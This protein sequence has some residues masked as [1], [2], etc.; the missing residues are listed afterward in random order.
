MEGLKVLYEQRYSLLEQFCSALNSRQPRKVFVHDLPTSH[1][2]H[3]LSASFI[4]RENLV[5]TYRVSL[6]ATE[7][8][9]AHLQTLIEQTKLLQMPVTEGLVVI[10]DGL[11]VQAFVTTAPHIENR[12]QAVYDAWHEAL[13]DFPLMETAVVYALEAKGNVI[14]ARHDDQV[15]ALWLDGRGE[16][17]L[18]N[19]LAQLTDYL[20]QA[21]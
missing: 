3:L 13:S 10:S 4:D 6:P 17:T 11:T 7:N 9:E 16:R 12:A 21:E 15:L 19:T 2:Q 8:T 14:Y 18:E 1:E 5:H 20:V